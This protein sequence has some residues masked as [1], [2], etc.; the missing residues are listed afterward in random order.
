MTISN[1][2]KSIR[3]IRKDVGGDEKE[4]EENDEEVVQEP[5]FWNSSI[6]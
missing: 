6:E 3:A 4:S 5:G 2:V 1:V